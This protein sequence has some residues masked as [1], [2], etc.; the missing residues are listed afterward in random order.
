MEDS[1]TKRNLRIRQAPPFGAEEDADD[2]N[3]LNN[4][5][6]L[7]AEPRNR[8]DSSDPKSQNFVAILKNF[9]C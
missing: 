4:A 6:S 3:T 1:S 2:E 9:A 7:I 8:G 5:V